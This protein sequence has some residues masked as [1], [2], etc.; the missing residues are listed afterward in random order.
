M[1]LERVEQRR[2]A[3]QHA[4]AGPGPRHFLAQ[5]LEVARTERG[6]GVGVGAHALPG[7]RV[8]HD[9]GVGPAGQVDAGKRVGH[10][11]HVVERPVHGALSGAAGSHERTVDVEQG[12]AG[13]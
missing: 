7:E 9:A 2:D 3:G 4:L 10:A 13:S 5:A 12:R 1:R 6:D 8:G 11:E